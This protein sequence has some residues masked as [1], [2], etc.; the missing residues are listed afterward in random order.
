M[1]NLMHFGIIFCFTAWVTE[2]HSHGNPRS[3]EMLA[4]LADELI[5]ADVD[6]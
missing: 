6:R 5:K 1:I 3:E 2:S 4:K